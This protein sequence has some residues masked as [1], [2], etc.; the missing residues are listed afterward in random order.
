[1]SSFIV[2]THLKQVFPHLSCKISFDCQETAIKKTEI[3]HVSSSWRN[4][5]PRYDS[6]ILQ[7][8]TQASIKFV[9]VCAMFSI[10]LVGQ[11]FRILV[12]RTYKKKCRNKVT[13]YIELDAAPDETFD[14]Y[15]L[16]SMIRSIHILPPTSSSSS[17]IVQDLHDGDM[18][19][20]LIK[21]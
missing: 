3:I 2:V 16:E 15:F 13:G 1:M 9:Q 18:Y 10:R 7:G 17:Y 14:F 5:G 21:S 4:S 11:T 12:A 19:L 20:R 8:P 6:A